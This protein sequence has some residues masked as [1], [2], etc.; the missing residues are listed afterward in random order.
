MTRGGGRRDI[1]RGGGG[2]LVGGTLAAYINVARNIDI[3]RA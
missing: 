2:E 3:Q 1:G